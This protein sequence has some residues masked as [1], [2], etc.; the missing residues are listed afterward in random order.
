MVTLTDIEGSVRSAI[1]NNFGYFSFSDVTA[2]Q[3]Y[4]MNARAKGYTFQTRPLN[5]ID[6]MTGFDFT[7]NP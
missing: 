5:V 6:E 1:S 4:L 2:G 7:A 3:S